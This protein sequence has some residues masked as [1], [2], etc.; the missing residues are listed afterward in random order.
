MFAS[1]NIFRYWAR[2]ILFSL[3]L[4]APQ[5]Q[6]QQAPAETDKNS[7]QP[8]ESV[9]NPDSTEDRRIERLGDV[10]TDQWE[11][12]LALPG[13]APAVSSGN[14]E[15]VLPDEEQNQKLQQ[16]LSSLA[17]NPD[18][19]GVL[20]QLSTLLTDVL[21][22]VN[23][24]MDTGS[25]EQAEQMFLLIQSID[26]G[27]AGLNAAKN[28]FQ[29]FNEVNDL[30]QAGSAALESGRILEP[31]GNNAL[32]HFSR[33]S[34][35]DPESLPARSGLEKV[36]E[37]LVGLALESARELDFETADTWLL[38]ASAVW[39]DQKQVEN[40][41]LEVATFKQQ[42]AEE[43]ELGAVRA[44]DSGDFNLV[45][46]NIIDLIALGGE[47]ARIESLRARL[48]DARLYGGFEPGQKITDE[49]LQSGG[50]APEIVIIAAGSFLM[51]SKGRSNDTYDNEKP[52]HR[53]TI[54]KGF[55]LGI[56]EVTVGEFRLFIERTGYQTAADRDGKS[57]VYDESAGRLS[58]RKGINWEFD[59]KGKKAK[60]EMPV[61]HVDLY[62]AQ[63]YVQW[64]ASETGKRYRLPSE[65]EYEYVARAGGSGTYWWGEGSPDYAVENLTGERDNSPGKRQWTTSFKKYG[66]GHWGPAPA[67]S[68][69]DGEMVHPIGVYDIAGNVSE[70]TED[71]WHQN[72]IKAPV[73]GSA[74]VNPGCVRRV[75]RGGYWASAPEQSRAAFRIS[76]KAETHGP[77]VG[78][79]IA[80]DL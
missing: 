47:Q 9:D 12:D 63:A 70:W 53:V 57:S 42:R 32:Y 50:H 10:S 28:R 13:A 40:A 17:A 21:G 35:L 66:D 31:E 39:Q 49:L 59:Y 24:L 14:G 18:N 69:G 45:D 71:C 16:L 6:A 15:W 11:M 75:A 23:N 33:A 22:Q 44:M 74:W 56:R 8:T 29:T 4:C 54:G 73:D 30:L 1:K 37:A 77:V 67:G 3:Y 72:Y 27:L 65:A 36:Q 61:L 78:F 80:R 64:L 34:N 46:F 20:A 51:G 68:V 58:N 19:A 5:S 79:R 25:F 60:P 43:L 41:R 7:L 26:P 38:E 55:G 48:K 76:A 62:D 2:L 52:Q